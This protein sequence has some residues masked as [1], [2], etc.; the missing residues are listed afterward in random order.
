M[1]GR[2]RAP[3][4]TMAQPVDI[5]EAT[6]APGASSAAKNTIGKGITIS[7]SLEFSRRPGQIPNLA[8]ALQAIQKDFGED[9]IA[10]RN[11]LMAFVRCHVQGRDTRH[12]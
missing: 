9:W 6:Q 8:S 11:A 7:A 3:E 5:V 12:W 10:Y 2:Q 1:S 4:T